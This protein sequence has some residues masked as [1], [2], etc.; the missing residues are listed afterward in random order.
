MPRQ[1]SRTS[2][3]VDALLRAPQI[4]GGLRD[5]QPP[6]IAG[7]RSGTGG[8]GGDDL[9]DA[10]SDRFQLIIR[11]RNRD[12]CH[13][14]STSATDSTSS[15]YQ[16]NTSTPARSKSSSHTIWSPSGLSRFTFNSAATRRLSLTAKMSGQP[17]HPGP[18]MPDANHAEFGAE[19]CGWLSTGR[20]SAVPSRSESTASR[21]CSSP[22]VPGDH[23]GDDM[24]AHS[25]AWRSPSRAGTDDAVTGGSYEVGAFVAG[26][27]RP[28]R[29]QQNH[30]VLGEQA[31]VFA[32]TWSDGV[33]VIRGSRHGF[34]GLQA[35]RRTAPAMAL[36]W[37]L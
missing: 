21:S 14:L 34:R 32:H 36:R 27:E 37:R 7:A 3:V 10:L 13:H 5:R 12:L 16:R 35:R 18:W 15:G 2:Q 4:V 17:I 6:R 23:C 22:L 11:E 30:A 8:F 26:H 24:R 29:F 28:I 19:S 1:S 31:C 33:V 20:G 9:G 25:P